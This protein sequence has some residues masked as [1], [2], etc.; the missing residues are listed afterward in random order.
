MAMVGFDANEVNNSIQSVIKAY[1]DLHTELYT[2]FQKNFVDKIATGW[3]AKYAVD[4]MKTVG[5]NEQTL[6]NE[7]NKV[8]ESVVKAMDGAAKAWA[9]QTGDSSVYSGKQISLKSTNIDLSKVKENEGGKRGIDETIVNSALTALATIKNN[10]QSATVKAR[11]AVNQCGFIGGSQA[12]DLQASL[13]E[14]KKGIDNSFDKIQADIEKGM[15]QTL[16]DYSA[17][18][19]KISSNFAGN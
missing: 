7:V 6:L 5:S 3:Y 13:T 18:E 1:D 16:Q 2:N 12:A 15:K 17:L 4:T 9:Q 14:I 11:Q 19:K 8:L 10:A